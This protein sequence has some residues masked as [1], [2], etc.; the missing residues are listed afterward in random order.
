MPDIYDRIGTLLLISHRFKERE[1]MIANIHFDKFV[2]DDSSG[3]GSYILKKC[4]N[5]A[6]QEE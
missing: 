5:N 4:A 2:S 6:K 3:E 1:V